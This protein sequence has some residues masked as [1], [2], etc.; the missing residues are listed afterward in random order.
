MAVILYIKKWALLSRAF[1]FSLFQT[2]IEL[3]LD[4]MDHDGEG[5]C[6]K[7]YL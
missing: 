4:I 1:F 6:K 3:F 7:D 2:Y 5:E